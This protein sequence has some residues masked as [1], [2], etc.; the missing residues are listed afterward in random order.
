MK[1]T[2]S[3][4]CTS[5]VSESSCGLCAPSTAASPELLAFLREEPQRTAVTGGSPGGA[6][7]PALSENSGLPT[8]SMHTPACC[9][10]GDSPGSIHV[11]VGPMLRMGRW[12]LGDGATV[13]KAT[14]SWHPSQGLAAMC[15][16]CCWHLCCLCGGKTS[17]KARRNRVLSK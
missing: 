16:R 2:R 17:Q 9:H 7:H 6:P 11:L 8:Q 15:G 3:G 14:Q 10:A 13:A 4:C 5:C 12:T 1:Y